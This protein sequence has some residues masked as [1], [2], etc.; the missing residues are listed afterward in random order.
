MFHIHAG[1]ELVVEDCDEQADEE[2]RADPTSKGL[3]VVIV[4]VAQR[5]WR[6]E[7]ITFLNYTGGSL[8]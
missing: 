8:S 3:E 5:Y 2:E 4:L 7:Q 6:T 1:H